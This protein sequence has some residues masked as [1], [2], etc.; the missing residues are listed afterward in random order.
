[1]S[2]IKKK[3]LIEEDM[4]FDGTT[5]HSNQYFRTIHGVSYDP[6]KCTC[7]ITG[8]NIIEVDETPEDRFREFIRGKD[9][10]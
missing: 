9:N 4:Y 1:M 8:T 2:K 3:V 5:A 6:E 10:E 7:T